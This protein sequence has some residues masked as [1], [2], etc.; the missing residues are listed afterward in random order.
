MAVFRMIVQ[1]LMLPMLDTGHDLSFCGTVA[2][3]F[4][5]DHH[6]R[7]D[8]LLLEQLAQQPLGCFGIASALDQDIE[9]GPMLVD[10]PPE[11]VLPAC[12]ADRNLIEVPP[13][14]GCRRRSWLA[15][16]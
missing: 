7:C 9:Y 15:K 10:R 14:T 2:R 13:V 4:V 5:G 8:A 3:E 11:P 12:N 1:S 6:A 16:S